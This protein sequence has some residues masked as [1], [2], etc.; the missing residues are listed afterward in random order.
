M[1]KIL[2]I[3]PE[4]IGKKMAGPGIRYY[5]LACQLAKNFQVTLA[6]YPIKKSEKTKGNF[7]QIYFSKINQLAPLLK[8]CDAIIALGMWPEAMLYFKKFRKFIICDLYDPHTFENLERDKRKKEKE[9][10]FSEISLQIKYQLLLG[11][12]F[13]CA[14]ERQK[15]YFLGILSA[16]G[17]INPKIYQNNPNLENFFTILPFGYQKNKSKFKPKIKG[18]IPGINKKDKVIIWGGGIW[19]WFDAQSVIFAF[20]DLIKKYPTWKLLFL[21]VRHP[22]PQIVQNNQL[23][24]CYQLASKFKLLNKNI[25]FNFDWIPYQE[26][27]DYFKE[28]D[29]GISTHFNNLE[30]RYAFRTRIISY[31]GAQ[32]PMVVTKGDVLANLVAKK[33]LGIV[34]DFEDINGLKKAI[35]KLLTSQKDYQEIKKNLQ[36]NYSQ[37]LISNLIKPLIKILKNPSPPQKTSQFFLL[38]LRLKLFLFR[39]FWKIKK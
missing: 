14:S 2:L 21:G 10:L 13:L 15:D 20:K 22:N 33:K 5:Q 1:K 26:Y 16:L 30:T 35:K 31:L 7:R 6:S 25:F 4:I 38:I 19:D 37:F 34:V 9:R 18:I 24:K 36:K 39:L 12:H 17:R 8:K 23:A 3:C 27:P 28:A 29:L 11:D 32:L